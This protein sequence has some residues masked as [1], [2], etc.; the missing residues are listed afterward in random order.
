MGGAREWL[1]WADI[2]TFLI[3]ESHSEKF[4]VQ[5]TLAHQSPI[6]SSIWSDEMIKEFKE[7]IPK[8]FR[9]KPGFAFLS[10]SRA[11]SGSR[12]LYIVGTNPGGNDW[13]D[14][15]ISKNVKHAL[16]N[17]NWSAYRD[18][19]WGRN[20]TKNRLQS[21]VLHLFKRLGL[22]AGEVPASEVVFLRSRN[23]P[24]LEGNFEKLAAECWHFHQ[25]VIDR[26]GVKV[27][28]C[29]GKRAGFWV[30]NRLNAQTRI[31]EF[32]EKNKR[33]WES[34]SHRNAD[35]LVIVTLTHASQASW[36]NPASDPTMLV[37]RALIRTDTKHRAEYL[38]RRRNFKPIRIKGE[39]IS[40]T[41]IRDRE[42]R[43]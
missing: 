14:Y 36:T 23:L 22:D 28:V 25:A 37:K 5:Y 31:D 33:Q 40:D 1:S 17:E 8:S 39:M 13:G 12:D 24:E 11:F 27:V 30:R 10:G 3:S 6:G 29:I 2:G 43:V 26:L 19:Y 16:A 42:D 32:V 21:G 35:G 20:C 9:N 34:H 41:V 7:L 4:A 15:T 38:A 18:D